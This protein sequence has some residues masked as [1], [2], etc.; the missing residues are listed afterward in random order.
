MWKNYTDGIIILHQGKV[1]YERYFSELN[2]TDVHAVMSL[3]KSFT[4]TL[5]AALVAEGV[6]DEHKLVAEYV[7]ELKNSGFGDATVRQVMDITTALEYSENY[8]DPNAEVWSFSAAGS[9]LP[10]SEDYDGPIGYYEYLE[11]VKKNGQHGE[12]FGYHTINADALGWIMAKATGKSVDELLSDKIWSR[13]GVEQDSYYQVDGLGTPFAGGGFNAGL[14]DLAR[15]GEMIRNKGEWQGKQIIPQA[16]VEDIEKG[17]SQEAFAKSDH[18]ELKGWSYRNMWWLCPTG[19]TE[20]EHGAFSARGVHGQAI[21]ID[22]KAEMVIV[23][24]ASHPVAANAA[25]DAYS[26]PAYQAVAEYLMEKN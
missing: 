24:L 8:A 2:E 16:A 21:Y 9:P 23:R 18:T 20:N 13:L 11:T 6:I 19:K 15:F 5:A 7:P 12:A 25:N 17:G 14:R 1:V 10:K 26:L 22:P 3:T 4:G